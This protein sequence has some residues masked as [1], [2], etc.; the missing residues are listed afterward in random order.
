MDDVVFFYFSKGIHVQQELS[1]CEL[2]DN[3]TPGSLLSRGAFNGV[4]KAEWHF[5]LHQ[6]TLQS[7]GLWSTVWSHIEANTHELLCA[8]VYAPICI[9]ALKNCLHVKKSH[10]LRKGKVVV[11]NSFFKESCGDQ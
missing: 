8:N 7:Q 6:N 2:L 1:G 4:D 11:S 9:K 5:S 3:D 10:V